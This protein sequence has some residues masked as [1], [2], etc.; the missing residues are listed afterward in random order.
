M[1]IAIVDDNI[2]Y[3][4][5]MRDYLSHIG[6]FEVIGTAENGFDA[7]RMIET[8]EPDIVLMDIAMPR[9]GGLGVL[10]KLQSQPMKNRPQFIIV[11]ALGQDKVSRIAVD[12]GADFFMIKPVDLDE[13]VLNIKH[14][15]SLKNFREIRNAQ[16][17]QSATDE[18]REE[19]VRALLD[20]IGMPSHLKGYDYIVYAMAIILNDLTAINAMKKQVYSRVSCKYNTTPAR[21]ERVIRNAVEL[22]WN[23]GKLDIIE[24]LFGFDESGVKTKP[25]NSEFFIKLAAEFM[26]KYELKKRS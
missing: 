22:T 19:R 18:E 13:L 25:S 17:E 5:I 11:T 2:S 1:R 26:D 20:Y 3:L 23:R 4:K 12:L 6:E 21:V 14:L 10:E 16:P 15:Y 9:L 7:C 24:K 8:Q